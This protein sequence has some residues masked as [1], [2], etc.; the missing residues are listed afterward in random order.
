[1]DRLRQAD[2]ILAAAASRSPAVLLP[3]RVTSPMDC[4]ITQPVAR[5]VVDDCWTRAGEP[6]GGPPPSVSDPAPDPAS[7]P[8]AETNADPIVDREMRRLAA[9]RAVPRTR[10]DTA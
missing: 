2:A 9:G 5:E 10:A 8:I 7:D 3:G 6:G 4:G 1:M